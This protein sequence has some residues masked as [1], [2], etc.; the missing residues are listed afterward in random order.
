MGTELV[1]VCCKRNT[2]LVVLSGEEREAANT[3]HHQWDGSS[4]SHVHGST[5]GKVHQ[6][7]CASTRTCH[8]HGGTSGSTSP[9]TRLPFHATHVSRSAYYAPSGFPG[10]VCSGTAWRCVTGCRCPGWLQA[11]QFNQTSIHHVSVFLWCLK[12]L[13][14]ALCFSHFS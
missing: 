8:V 10:S 5:A 2:Y 7:S 3:D 9:Q 11:G 6:L 4:T 1:C 14:I 12:L 13:I